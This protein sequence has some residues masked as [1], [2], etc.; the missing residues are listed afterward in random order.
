[1]NT[2]FFDD[3]QIG[4]KTTSDEYYVSKKEVIDFAEK[5]DPQPFHIDEEAARLSVFGELT[6]SA[7]HTF[8][9]SGILTHRLKIKP[10]VLAAFG[11]KELKFP[12][13]VRPGDQ[14]RFIRECIEKRESQS[15][16]DTGIVT[17]SDT[18]VNQEELVVASMQTV[19][20]LAK[21]KPE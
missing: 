1:M 10:A 14:L 20:L 16:P 19:L 17:F 4:L 2:Y 3:Y 18:L 15:R 9:I 7:S 6:A 21:K 5:W 11:F 13:P 8:C 12:K